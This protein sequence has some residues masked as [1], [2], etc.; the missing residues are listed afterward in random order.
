M[1]DRY[2]NPDFADLL[3]AFVDADVRFLIVGAYALGA[4][5]H[6][7]ATGDL[8]V[9]IESSP[10]NAKRTLSALTSFGAPLFGLTESDLTRPGTVFQ[11]GLPPA[12]IDVLNDVSGV[13]FEAAWPNRIETSIEGVTVPVIGFDDLLANKR[14]TGRDKDRQDAAA[15]ERVARRRR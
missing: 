11:M 1:A 13:A 15:L 6:V 12:R 4:H 5:G 7:R 10:G 9:R 3:R 8:D 14:A 2:P